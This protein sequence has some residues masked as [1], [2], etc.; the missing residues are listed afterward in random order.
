[1]R[2]L[3]V[4]QFY[5]PDPAP[6]GVLLQDLVQALTLRGHE[7]SVLC[8]RGSYAGGRRGQGSETRDGIP[9]ERLWPFGFSRRSA[10]GKVLDYACFYAGLAARLCAGRPRPDLVVVLTS[11]PFMGALAR[12]VPGLGRVARAVWI[13]D[14]YPDV[15]AAHGV[16]ST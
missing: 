16:A 5:P 10:V 7:V 6:T 3:A 15:M 2:V 12:R 4:N 9:V 13:M 14:L 8:S 11:P 1:M